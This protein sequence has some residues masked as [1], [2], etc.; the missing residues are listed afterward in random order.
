MASS[1]KKALGKAETKALGKA[2]KEMRKERN[3]SQEAAALTCEIDRTYFGKLE[4]AE[5]SPTV[6]MLWRIA[7][8]LKIPPSELLAR[9]EKIL[10][11]KA[12]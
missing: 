5:Q 1:K 11:E 8:G 4:R 3:L 12:G 9:S 7:R 6:T 10:K 2:L